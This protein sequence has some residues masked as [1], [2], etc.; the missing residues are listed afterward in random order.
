MRWK[1]I[2]LAYPLHPKRSQTLNTR[3]NSL[4]SREMPGTGV[5]CGG[6]SL[7]ASYAWVLWCCSILRR[8]SGNSSSNIYLCS[9][10]HHPLSHSLMSFRTVFIFK[11]ERNQLLLAPPP[12]HPPNPQPPKVKMLLDILSL[13]PQP[14]R[15]WELGISFESCCCVLH[16][17]GGKDS[18]SECYEFSYQLWSSW[19]QACLG[20]K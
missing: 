2:L 8:G 11:Q 16:C 10:H 20:M 1:F 3:F 17:A 15:Y 5:G 19:L 6:G 12:P 18:G 4:L 7:F 13:F 14:Q 9:Y